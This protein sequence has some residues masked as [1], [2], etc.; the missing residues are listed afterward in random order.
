MNYY[1]LN[2]QSPKAD[3]KEATI[4]GQAPDK[5]L[6]FPE[7]IPQLP[8]ELITNIDKYSR[9]EIAFTVIRPYVGNTIP[10][11]ELKRIVAET[12]DFDF[13]LVKLNEQIY[14]LELFHGPTLAFKDVGAR[15][16]SRCL[17]YFVKGS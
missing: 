16:M 13:P 5:G 6:Y 7:H 2:N 12:I 14:S 9:E 11:N 1:S 3:F 17:G 10:E 8:K 4:R 15:F